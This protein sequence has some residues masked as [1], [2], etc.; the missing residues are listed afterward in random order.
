MKLNTKKLYS[1]AFA[2]FCVYHLVIYLFAHMAY[3]YMNEDIGMIFE[4]IRFYIGRVTD[5][6]TPSVIGALMLTLYSYIDT[7]AAVK[8]AILTSSTRIIHT[9][10]YY[11]IIF[12]YNYGYDS[13]EAILLSVFA[14]LLSILFTFLISIISL[15]IGILVIR[16]RN[17]LDKSQ[18]RS[19]LCDAL[20]NKP[21]GDFLTGA[22]TALLIFP[23]ISFAYLFIT[24]IIDTVSFFIE[25][26]LDYTAVEIITILINYILLLVMIAVGYIVACKVKNA[27]ISKRLEE[28]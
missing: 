17:K 27:I 14:S 6:I 22:N 2:L 28:E 11:Y 24:E 18:T 1:K 5:F 7:R 13:L 21:F 12:I 15:G 16:K 10:P 4:Y 8:M 23:A 3:L 20:P 25:Y 26:K 19:Y 9:L